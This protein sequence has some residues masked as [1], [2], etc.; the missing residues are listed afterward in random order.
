[1]SSII[2]NT[3]QGTVTNLLENTKYLDQ[4]GSKLY[5]VATGTDTYAITLTPV[6]TSYAAGNAYYVKFTNGNT[7]PATINVNGL[8]AKS[9]VKNLSSA[10]V[11][12]D[13][14]TGRTT[15]IIYDGTNFIVDFYDSNGIHSNISGEV[16]ALTE[17]P[18]PIAGD[19]LVLEDSASSNVKRKASVGN[20]SGAATW[21]IT[22]PRYF[23]V[24]YDSG[25]DSNLGYS[26]SS[27]SA[28]GSV[29]KKT[30]E[31]LINVFP[32]T[33]AGRTAVVAIKARASGTIYKKQDGSTDAELDFLRGIN[34]YQ[35][36]VIRGTGTNSTAG[37]TA[38]ANDAN[39]KLYLGAQT[40]SGANAAGYNPIAS[41]TVNT[42]T[43]KFN[44]GGT[45]SLAAEPGIL[46]KRLR[47]DSNTS[48]TALRNICRMVHLNTSTSITIDTDLPATPTTSDIFYLEEPGA[49]FDRLTVYS[50][51]GA[52]LALP[53]NFTDNGVAIAGF[54]FPNTG[55]SWIAVACIGV[56]MT[57]LSFIDVA[58]PS[59]SAVRCIHSDRSFTIGPSYVDE[60]SATIT[61][62]LGIRM[63]GWATMSNMVTATFINS[64][65]TTGRLQVLTVANFTIGAGSYLNLGILTQN[66]RGSTGGSTSPLGNV[67][68]NSASTTIRRLRVVGG[69]SGA[70]CVFQNT[71]L[72]IRG[73]DINNVGALS[74]IR[75][76]GVGISVSINDVVGSTGNTSVGLDLTGARFAKI[77]MGALNANTFTGTA[78]QDIQ[79]VGPI[80]YV[81]ADYDV[82][83]L[84]D[85]K[86]NLIAG[87]APSELGPTTFAANDG[88]A[89]ITK[90]AI[91]RVTATGAVRAARAN[92]STN[93]S[94]VVGIAQ[95][96]ATTTQ[97]L[98]LGVGGA[99]WLQF[100]STPTVGN[101]AYLSTAADGNAQHT[102]PTLS[103]TNQKLRLGRILRVSGTTGLV[104]WHPESLPVL[105]DGAA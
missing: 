20:V 33:G 100:D 54:R 10:L 77:I 73:I 34:G 19:W 68:G 66:C 82:S 80:Y 67:A 6:P 71:D 99:S 4:D 70:C 45:P 44:G 97:N 50:T 78:N 83:E 96:A 11:S 88:N 86:G 49:A 15:L 41:P 90:F 40:A 62:G 75:L 46:G 3:N 63:V 93:A 27:M 98:M 32:K 76:D 94:M 23:A 103:G 2:T 7:G 89:N 5:A 58:S 74:L 55:A 53:S 12:G 30:I 95:G 37:A 28:A 25:S 57:G 8:G 29:A 24:D 105:A 52:A 51:D 36:I 38:F 13:I 87:T 104:A 16:N 102:A 14:S 92:S 18:T 69:F 65:S 61:T 101:I 91:C 22:S 39:D 21:T 81:H 31:G 47:F 84:R 48:V 64:V 35:Q 43:C 56:G 72:N 42:F 9:L 26:D 59:T 60:S 79:G 85:Q 1:M 17:K